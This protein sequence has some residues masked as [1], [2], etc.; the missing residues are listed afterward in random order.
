MD[1]VK[2]E[3]NLFRQNITDKDLKKYADY[4]HIYLAE[5]VQITDN[6]LEHL[7]NVTNINLKRC[8]KITDAGLANLPKSLTKS[9]NQ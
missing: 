8:N 9:F 4:T 6:G 5:N 1:Y 2:K 7:A 3:I